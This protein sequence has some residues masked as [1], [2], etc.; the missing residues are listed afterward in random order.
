M[1][2]SEYLHG[3]G[4]DEPI[5]MIKNNQTYYYHADGLGSIIAITDSYGRVVQ[6]YEYN[7]FGEITYIQD[8]NFVQ[9]YTYTG[10]EYDT[11]SG[12]YYYRA[13][14]YDAKIGRFLQRDPILAPINLTTVGLSQPINKNIWLL[15][16]V[17][18]YPKLLQ[19]YAYAG[20]NPINFV[21]PEGLT[22]IFFGRPWFYF[23]VPPRGIPPE[24]WWQW[25]EP[26]LPPGACFPKSIPRPPIPPWWDKLNPEKWPYKPEPHY[27]PHPEPHPPDA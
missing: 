23:R 19:P 18:G 13:R 27:H 11:E 25:S 3:P 17:I 22:S 2:R 4:I 12:L 9:P 6:K 21:D 14:Y 24:N 26:N 8:P 7:S 5:A 16:Y 1:N 10:R 15:P 20:S